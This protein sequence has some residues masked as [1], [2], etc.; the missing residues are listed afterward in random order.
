MGWGLP[1]LGP[2]WCPVSRVRLGWGAVGS[3]L[4]PRVPCRGP[5]FSVIRPCRSRSATPALWANRSDDDPGLS[6]PARGRLGSATGFVSVDPP[7]RLDGIRGRRRGRISP[8]PPCDHGGPASPGRPPIPAGS[9]RRSPVD[10]DPISIRLDRARRSG[11]DT[12]AVTEAAVSDESGT[13]R[14]G[15]SRA[16]R[17]SPW[18]GVNTIRVGSRNPSDS[19]ATGRRPGVCEPGRRSGQRSSASSSARAR[20]N[21]SSGPS[22][23]RGV[24]PPIRKNTLWT[25]K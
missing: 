20:S 24:T 1:W 10:F 9:K 15:L 11:A 12:I 7:L 8:G 6:G 19:G 23:R 21:G 14:R 22:A 17:S 18:P 25:R 5:G 4:S 16:R 2:G 13:T 3:L